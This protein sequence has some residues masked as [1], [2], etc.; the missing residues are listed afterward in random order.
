M[1]FQSERR[2][3]QGGEGHPDTHNAPTAGETT[4]TLFFIYFTIFFYWEPTRHKTRVSWRDGIG[5]QVRE[6]RLILHHDMQPQVDWNDRKLLPGQILNDVPNR[7]A[8]VLEMKR[9]ELVDDI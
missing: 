8:R 7:I 5:D 2:T 4:I 3:M 6:T 1:H 9:T